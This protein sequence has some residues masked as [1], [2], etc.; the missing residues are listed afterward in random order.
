MSN[1]Q[2]NFESILEIPAQLI[3]QTWRMELLDRAARGEDV[4]AY[5]GHHVEG[6]EGEPRWFV[7]DGHALQSASSMYHGVRYPL[8]ELERGRP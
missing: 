7:W 5:T 1:A 2:R 3:E 6:Q 8:D 4:Y